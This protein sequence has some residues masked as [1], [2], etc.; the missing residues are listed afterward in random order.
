MDLCGGMHRIMTPFARPRAL[1]L[2]T[3]VA[4]VALAVAPTG[5]DAQLNA[6]GDWRLLSQTSPINPIHVALLHTGRVL[7]VAGSENDP[8][9]TTYRAAVWD[10]V[11][12]TVAVQ[13]IPWDLFCNAMSFLPDGRVITTGGNMQYNPFTGIR[14]TTIFDPATQTFTQAQDM[15]HGRWYPSNLSLAD[16]STMTFSGWLDTGGTNNAVEIYRLSSGWSAEMFAPFSPPLYPWLHLLPDG[17]VFASGSQLNSHMFDPTTGQWTLNVARMRYA[18]DPKQFVEPCKSSP[19]ERGYGSSVL[20]P[21]RPS[22]NY[23]ARVMIMGGDTSATATAEIIDFAQPTPAWRSLPSMSAP[24]SDMN[25]VLLPNGKVLAL[26]GSASRETESTASLNADIFDPVSETWSPAGR[27]ARAR[28]YHSVA[29]LLPD[30]TVWVAGSNPY[31][32]AWDS[33]MEIYRPPYLFTSAG[34]LAARPTISSAP[35]SI[36]YNTAFQV[37]TPD[38]ANIAS[39]VLVRAGSATHAFDFEQRMIALSFTAGAGTLSLTAPPNANIAPPGYYMLF[40]LNQAGVPSSASWVQVSA[41]SGNQPPRGTI[42]S[43]ATDVTIRAGDSVTFAGSGSDPDGTIASYSWTFPGGTP[44]SSSSATPGAVVFSTAGVYDVTLMVTDNAGASDPSPPTRR[45]TVQPAGLTASFTSPA[46]NATV[47]GIQ[48]VGMSVTN[49][50]GNSNTFTLTIDGVQ[51]YTTT[52][53]GTTASQ[54]WDT[55]SASNGAHTL[56]LTVRD[57]SSATATATLSVIVNNNV[58]SGEITVTFPNL[59]AG[60]AVRGQQTVQIQAVNTAGASNRF[61]ISVDG[62][63]QD[64]VFTNATTITWTWNTIGFTNGSHTIAAMVND[65]TGRSG[66]G[67]QYVSVQ[68]SLPVAITSPAQGATVSSVT[69]VDVWVDF[70]SGASNVF[71]LLVNGNVVAQQTDSGRHVTLPWDTTK[72]PNGAQTLVAQVRDASGNG[73]QFTRPVTV[74]NAINPPA[75]SFTSPA[76]GTTV[77]GTVS[78]GLRAAGGTAP[79]TYRLTIDGTSVFT[80]TVSATTASYSWPTAS[81]VNGGH[82]LV[83]TVTDSR[84]NGTTATRIVNTQNGGTPAAPTA[85]FTSPAAGATV[86]GASVAVGMAAAGGTPGYTYSLTLDGAPLYTSPSTT[87]TTASYSWNASGVANGSHTLGLTVTDSLGATATATR[88]VTVQNTGAVTAAFTTP[89]PGATVSGAAVTIG[90]AAGGGTPGYTY[91]LTV[92]GAQVFTTTTTATS[93]SFAW[94][95]TSVVDGSHTLGLT[96]T[97]SAGLSATAT[98]TVTVSNGGGTLQ[99]FLTQPSNGTTVSGINWAVIWVSGTRGTSNV[100][101]LSVGA[102]VVATTTTSSTGPVSIPWDTTTVANGTQTLTATVRDATA[103]SGTSSATVFVQNGATALSASFTTPAAGATVSGTTVAVGMAAGGGSPAYTYR[104]TID[105]TQV[106]TT[107]STTAVSYTWNTTGSANG[108]HTLGLTVTDTKGASVTATRTV[109][110]ANAGPLTAAITT[111]AAGATVSGTT[112][113]VGMTASGGTPAY[114]YKLTVDGLQVF[115][116]STTATS[117]SATWNSTTVANGAHT[118]TL[119]VTDAAGATATATRTVTVNNVSGGTFEIFI[120]APAQ[121]QTVSGTVW[122]TIW[123]NSTAAGARAY[124]FTVGGTTVWSESTSGNPVAL[125][126]VTPNGPNG[127]QTLV[128]TVRDSANATGTASVTVTVQNP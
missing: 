69:W 83:L 123:N 95:S 127:Q 108:A 107:T 96:V 36:G 31:Q 21:L 22:D 28:M 124:T 109:T 113:A 99:V 18:Q 77:S 29:L 12:G 38:A 57:A 118:L 14:T 40:V 45:I 114:T 89:A 52:T 3:L 64:L 60:Q 79:Y 32:G 78:V 81:Y 125:P 104:L 102:Q 44:T 100:Y 41:T 1:L 2:L 20:L 103:N 63:V 11:A 39:V 111:P 117:A 121:G 72:T 35:A 84:G 50:T 15:A 58:S 55:R 17:R 68:N 86:G 48:P 115:T 7:I 33:S 59:A 56:G 16:G 26:G 43:P 73:G 93:A 82:A 46:P 24:R 53:T 67:S 74:Q 71:T 62:A 94:N 91:A 88:T 66:T 75:A 65:A 98:L 51:A 47:A 49:A 13:T 80:S 5:A 54:N 116:T 101:T 10:P 19:C 87:A 25:A 122:V 85:S 92:D 120:T 97:D 70:P 37:T 61:E 8:T 105:G 106:F 110:V 27:M 128:V 34:A 30:A 119:T 76:A 126:W 112:V 6:T 42:T 4:V 9:V 90:M 23:R